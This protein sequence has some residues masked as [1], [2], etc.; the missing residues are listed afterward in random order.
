MSDQPTIPPKE[1]ASIPPQN[2]NP[3]LDFFRLTASTK[4]TTKVPNQPAP[5][6]D[7]VSTFATSSTARPPAEPPAQPPPDLRLH[8]SSSSS[9]YDYQIASCENFTLYGTWLVRNFPGR[10][11]YHDRTFVHDVLHIYDS[12]DIFTS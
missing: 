9:S 4:S 5:G 7:P 12:Q 1:G 3:F 8:P 2:P 10:F 6:L 11:H